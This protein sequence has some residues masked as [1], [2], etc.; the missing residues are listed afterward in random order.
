M[1]PC[2]G[3]PEVVPAVVIMHGSAGV[4]SRG[5]LYARELNLAGIATLEVDMW[6]ARGLFNYCKLAVTSRRRIASGRA[7]FSKMAW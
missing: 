5:A 7:P 2:G 6:G 1:G 4:D 3:E